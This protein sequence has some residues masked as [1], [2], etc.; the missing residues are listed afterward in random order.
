MGIRMNFQGPRVTF[1]HKTIMPPSKKQKF[2][3]GPAGSRSKFAVIIYTCPD[4]TCG[5]CFKTKQ[6][7]AA[8][9]GRSPTCTNAGLKLL[10]LNPGP[11]HFP[12][13]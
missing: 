12:T 13:E 10:E 9:F 4:K 5:S 8:H 3:H 6:G 1:S 11:E 2:L 7:L